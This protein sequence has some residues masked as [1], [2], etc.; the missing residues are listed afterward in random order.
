MRT[1]GGAP[2]NK[3]KKMLDRKRPFQI[4]KHTLF[5]RQILRMIVK[6]NEK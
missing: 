1:F 2:P 6:N 5:L 3:G 4:Y